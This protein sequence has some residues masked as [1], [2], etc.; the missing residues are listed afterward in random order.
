[1]YPCCRVDTVVTPASIHGIENSTSAN[2]PFSSKISKKMQQRR[3]TTVE[4]ILREKT[5]WSQRVFY[6]LMALVIVQWL[7]GT[8]SISI[9][10]AVVVGSVFQLV[11]FILEFGTH[12][13]FAFMRRGR[14]LRRTPE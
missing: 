10:N 3:N 5:V 4:E 13:A 7:S 8:S 12:M 9:V 1:M 14:N 11:V 2:K 6:V